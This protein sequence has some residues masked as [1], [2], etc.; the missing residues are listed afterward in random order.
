MLPLAMD[1]KLARYGEDVAVR[2][3][4]HGLSVDV[5]NMARCNCTCTG[6]INING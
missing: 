4:V 6:A 2:E 3:A 1:R 5:I